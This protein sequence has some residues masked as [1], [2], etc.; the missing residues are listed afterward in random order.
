MIWSAV[1]LS[2]QNGSPSVSLFCVRVPVLS[3]H[4]T[5]TP[6]SSS[7]A[8]NLLTIACFFASRRAPT[9]MVTDRTVGIA[10]GIAATVSTRANC[11]VVRIGLPAINSDSDDHRHQDH[12]QHDQVVADP[13][14]GFLKMA[15]R[16]ARSC[17]LKC[18]EES[19]ARSG[20]VQEFS[21][22]GVEGAVN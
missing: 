13:Q 1:I 21:A 19:G 3:A 22:D 7:M 11:N 16:E 2:R 9:A 8:T 6:A 20:Q 5:S 14:H 4:S 12:R 10:T 15:V 18:N 17:L